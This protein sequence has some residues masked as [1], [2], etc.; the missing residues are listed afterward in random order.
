MQSL[1]LV[2]SDHR[3]PSNGGVG[4]PVAKLRGRRVARLSKRRRP[5]RSMNVTVVGCAS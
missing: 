3:V 1:W 4:L 5:S 2:G